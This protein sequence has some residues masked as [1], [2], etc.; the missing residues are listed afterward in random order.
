MNLN[1]PWETKVDSVN[2]DSV[3]MLHP[4]SSQPEK[5]PFHCQNNERL[6]TAGYHKEKG[7]EIDPTLRGAC[8]D[9]TALITLT[10][11]VRVRVCAQLHVLLS[12]SMQVWLGINLPNYVMQ[13]GK[14]INYPDCKPLTTSKAKSRY[15]NDKLKALGWGLIWLRNVPSWIKIRPCLLSLSIWNDPIKAKIAQT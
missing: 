2:T 15:V 4:V 5:L 13:H 1:L 9:I 7:R 10:L 11:C 12:M 8:W 14:Y 3:V 6:N